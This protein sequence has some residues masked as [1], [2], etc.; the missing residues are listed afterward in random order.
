[1]SL[2]LPA[3][4]EL[5]S[6]NDPASFHTRA[7]A[8]FQ[9]LESFKDA[10]NA[11]EAADY[12][13]VQSTQTDATD[14][15]LLKLGAFGLGKAALLTGGTSFAA[16]MLQ[17]GFY[18]YSANGRTDAPESAPWMHNMMVMR[19]HSSL[20]TERMAA[21]DVRTTGTDHIRAWIGAQSGTGSNTDDLY[22]SELFHQDS[23]VGTVAE[24]A[25]RPTGAVIERGSNANG[26]YV[27]FADG[28]QICTRHFGVN[29]S[30]HSWTFPAA[31]V[32]TTGGSL[33]LSAIPFGASSVHVTVN[34]TPSTTSAEFMTWAHDG[35]AVSTQLHVTAIG[36]WF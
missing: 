5:P 3:A 36:R 31:F 25:G 1:M 35:T 30:S 15:N 26:Q 2:S 17:S 7:L 29:A 21:L 16:R 14:G 13:S 12:F 23:I 32:A 33:A 34:W 28:T 24:D 20:G 10:L 27:R 8:Y 22:W 11:I 19:G 18:S 9:W 6:L 4:P